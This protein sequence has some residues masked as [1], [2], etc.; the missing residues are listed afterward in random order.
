MQFFPPLIP[1]VSAPLLPAILRF[2]AISLTATVSP[3]DSRLKFSSSLFRESSRRRRR[4]RERGRSERSYRREGA[5]T[6]GEHEDGSA[7][8][9][10]GNGRRRRGLRGRRAGNGP[11]GKG[12]QGIAAPRDTRGRN[13]HDGTGD[14]LQSRSPPN[15]E[16]TRFACMNGPFSLACL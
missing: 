15:H 10:A 13:L 4:R 5:G 2:P 16:V 1:R 9:T 3:I 6:G 12:M 8:G 7:A 11:R 14:V